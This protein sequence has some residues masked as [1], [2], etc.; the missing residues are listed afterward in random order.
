V[1][2]AAVAIDIHQTLD[3][4]GHFRSKFTFNFVVVFNDVTDRDAFFFAEILD[5]GAFL[6]TGLIADLH[7]RRPAYSENIR[8]T[9][10][11]PFIVRDINTSNTRHWVSLLRSSDGRKDNSTL[12]LLM[13]FVL[14]DHTDDSLAP[15]DLA[16]SADFSD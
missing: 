9:D 14:A 4:E 10:D 11:Y 5:P 7:G 13:A 3:V 15:Y 1:T 16:L 12:S 8:Q 6:H 2:P